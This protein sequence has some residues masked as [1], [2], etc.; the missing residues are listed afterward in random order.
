MKLWA[1]A[2]TGGVDV[3]KTSRKVSESE[4]LDVFRIAE[5]CSASRMTVRAGL[6]KT[7]LWLCEQPAASPSDADAS[8]GSR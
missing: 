8:A 5:C 1:R 4:S 3:G 7:P 2:L 6:L